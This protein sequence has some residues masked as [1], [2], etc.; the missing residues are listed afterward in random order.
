MQYDKNTFK[1]HFNQ[2]VGSHPN[3][4]LMEAKEACQQLIP[5]HLQEKYQWLV[6]ESLN[7]FVWQKDFKIQTGFSADPIP[8]HKISVSS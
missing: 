7:W 2:W 4:D 1:T 8:F 3:A 6:Q 5:I